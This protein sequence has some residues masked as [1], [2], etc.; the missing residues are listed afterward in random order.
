MATAEKRTT[1]GSVLAPLLFSVHTNDQLIHPNT[2]SFLDADVLVIT[3]QYILYCDLGNIL[4]GIR[5]ADR[6]L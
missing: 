3:A 5:A 4:I 1:T 6:V 2:R